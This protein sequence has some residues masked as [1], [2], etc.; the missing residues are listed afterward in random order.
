MIMMFFNSCESNEKKEK[1][2]VDESFQSLEEC[3]NS[4]DSAEFKEMFNL[5]LTVYLSLGIGI[6][7]IGSSISI[8]KYLEV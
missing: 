6:G 3:I 4:K 2:H 8:K 5:I 1:R 7:V